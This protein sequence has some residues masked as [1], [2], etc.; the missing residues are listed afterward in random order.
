MIISNRFFVTC[1]FFFYKALGEDEIQPDLCDCG[2]YQCY[3]KGVELY[4]GCKIDRPAPP[5]YKCFCL[6][7]FIDTCDG[8]GIKCKSEKEYGCNGCDEEKCCAGNCVGYCP[9]KSSNLTAHDH[10]NY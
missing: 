9:W 6:N 3:V 4:S 7:V 8:R 5:G 1:N 10:E 2:W